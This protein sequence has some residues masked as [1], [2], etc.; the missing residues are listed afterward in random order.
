MTEAKGIISPMATGNGAY[1]LHKVIEGRLSNYRVMDYSPCLTLFPPL[2]PS[3]IGKMRSALIHATPDY[4][5]FFRRPRTPLILTIHNYVCDP[6]MRPFSSI[7]QQIHYATDL[8]WF[9]RCSLKVATVVTSVSRFSAELLQRHLELNIPIRLIYNGV[10]EKRFHPGGVKNT[11]P[12]VRVLFSG[13]LTWRKGAQWLPFIAAGLERGIVLHYTSGLGRS[14]LGP[15]GSKLVDL[16]RLPWQSMAEL[17]RGFDILVSPTVREGFGLAI[18][19]AMACGLPVV[20]SNCSAVPELV[21]DGLGGF[22]CPVGDVGAFAE[23][24]NLL[25]QAPDLRRRMGEYNRAKV[26]KLFTLERMITEYRELFE[27]LL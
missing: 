25:A 4:G 5:L 20:A 15:L 11:S 24:I 8:R 13:N 6:W 16:G 27:S 10:D 2:L 19:E 3:V 21:D 22:L 18:A 7:L 14:Q 26:E 12:M 9:I 23:K 1:V 17:Y